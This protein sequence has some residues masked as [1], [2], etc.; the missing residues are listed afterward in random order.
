M[1][2]L[3]A[4]SSKQQSPNKTGIRL[5]AH[6]G[7]CVRRFTKKEN[8]MKKILLLSLLLLSTV[9]QA[10]PWVVRF[11]DEKM[12]TQ[13]MLEHD[14]WATPALGTASYIKSGAAISSSAVTTITTFTAQPDY[15]RNILL[16]PT[17]TT[18]NVA[19]G[20]AVVNGTNIFG[21]AISE[22]FTISS[23][24]STATTGAKAFATVTSVV[25]PQASGSGV[26]LSIGTG[27]KLGIRRCMSAVGEYVFSDFGGVYD[28]TRGTMVVNSTA[29]ESNTFTSNSA[30]DGSSRVD[31]HYLQNYRCF[32]GQ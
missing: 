14:S 26:T 21:K 19:A 27:A 30:L 28:T 6:M 1:T 17:G 12:P 15:P 11:Q 7:N 31:L 2:Q 5:T 4:T 10:G 8:F 9:V 13:Q 22:N 32:G 18:A 29:V 25:F 3:A 24:Q 20:T 23:T 16:T